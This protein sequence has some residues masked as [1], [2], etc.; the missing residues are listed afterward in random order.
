MSETE[1]HAILNEIKNKGQ[2]PNSD[3]IGIDSDFNSSDLINN[4]DMFETF[5][6]KR[7]E[8]VSIKQSTKKLSFLDKIKNMF[9]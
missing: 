1:L 6:V 4:E 5:S 3:S 9:K 2:V 7:E 8:K